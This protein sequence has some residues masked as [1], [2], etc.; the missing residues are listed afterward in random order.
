[1]SLINTYREWLLTHQEQLLET[2]HHLHSIAEISWE[3][4]IT[5]QYLCNRVE[6]LGIPFSTFSDHTGLVATW[7]G[8]QEGPII[9]IRADIDALWQNVDGQWKA[10]HSCG[11]DAHSTM[12]LYAIKLLKE[13]GFRPKGTIKIIFQPAEETGKGAKALIEKGVLDDIN[14]LIGIHVRPVQELYVR[15]ASAAIYHGATM[16][17]KGKVKGLQAHAARPHLGINVLDSIAAIIQAVNSIKLDPTISSSAKVTMVQTEGKN[18]NIIPDEAVFGLDLRAESNEAMDE[19]ANKVKRAIIAA[20]NING[21]EVELDTMAKTVAAVPNRLMETI[22]AEAIVE[23]LGKDGLAQPL[24]TP[25]GED[26][27]L[28]AVSKSSLQATMVGLGA[29]LTPGLHHPNMTFDLSA[30]QD[31]VEILARSL[32]KLFEQASK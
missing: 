2:Y 18:M 14:Y 25:G 23:V 26:F 29:D 20:A 6:E 27:H 12:V 15:Q 1:M 24:V 7:S 31:G 21:A 17:L 19:L 13:E 28:Y 11:H 22:V 8:E 4:K 3:E 10:N 16:V 5:T 9:G 30:L 32:K